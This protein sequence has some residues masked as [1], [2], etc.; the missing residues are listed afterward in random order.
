[1]LRG[2]V[3]PCI[4][5]GAHRVSFIEIADVEIERGEAGSVSSGKAMFI[6][7]AGPVR[8]RVGHQDIGGGLGAEYLSVGVDKFRCEEVVGGD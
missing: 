6:R 8:S 7:A 1:M 2:P 5:S 3:H 4:Y